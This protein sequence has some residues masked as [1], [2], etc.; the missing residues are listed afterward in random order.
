MLVFA[1]DIS[2][3][4]SLADDRST[5]HYNCHNHNTIPMR[6]IQISTKQYTLGNQ[7]QYVLSKILSRMERLRREIFG[8]ILEHF[9][10]QHRALGIGQET[11]ERADNKPQ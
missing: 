4:L 6:I 2:V 7:G 8:S 3:L 11:H 10:I 9:K 5:L 1:C